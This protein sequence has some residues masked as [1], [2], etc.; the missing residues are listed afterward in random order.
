MA[1]AVSLVPAMAGGPPMDTAVEVLP[2]IERV[3]PTPVRP[4]EPS[5]SIE[6]RPKASRPA[7]RLRCK[8]CNST[9]VWRFGRISW[10]QYM[11]ANAR[12]GQWATCR[13]CGKRFVTRYYGPMH[14]DEDDED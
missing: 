2:A 13:R 3:A 11:I 4:A 1:T 14:A 5:E 9:D 7:E 6:E 12:S 10:I 8:R